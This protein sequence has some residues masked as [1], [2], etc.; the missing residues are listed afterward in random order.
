MKARSR[1]K[2]FFLLLL[3]VAAGLFS[4]SDYAS[5][6][7]QFLQTYAGDTLWSLAL[8]I[9][10]AFV[11]PRAGAKELLLVALLIS[12]G[13]E[14]SQKYQADWINSLRNTTPGGLILGFGFKWS[15]LLC[16][17]AGILFGFV[18]DFQKRTFW[19]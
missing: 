8:Y 6:L 12:F 1:L 10:L 19:K 15:D 7:P 5:V 3:V 16:Y 14:F 18:I 11:S 2:L 9:F 4:R 13:V 17:T